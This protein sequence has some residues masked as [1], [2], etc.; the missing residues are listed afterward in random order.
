MSKG[1]FQKST[2][3][4]L[5]IAV[6]LSI[7]PFVILSGYAR[8]SGDDY[9]YINKLNEYGYWSVQKYWFMRWSGR[10]F[11]TVVISAFL[12]MGDPVNVARIPGFIIIAAQLAALIVLVAVWR[13]RSMTAM[14]VW[15][16]AMALM[17]VF[18]GSMAAYYGVKEIRVGRRKVPF[19]LRK[20]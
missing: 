17:A 19:M 18:L 10:Y 11:A 20:K 4:V 3:T 8:P 15:L 14:E 2:V 5:I 1:H 16:P 6:I 12:L 7:L 13:R 9:R